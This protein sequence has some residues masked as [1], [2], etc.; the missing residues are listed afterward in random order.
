MN[1]LNKL[2][3]ELNL[4]K[5]NDPQELRKTIRDKRASLSS[6]QIQQVSIKITNTVCNLEIFKTS[7]IIASY[8]AFNSEVDPEQITNCIWQANKSCYL[9]FVK[10]DKMLFLKYEREDR[11]IKNR[12]GILEPIFNENKIISPEKIDLVI[13]PLVGFDIHC[14][15]LGT[16]KGYYDRTFAFLKKSSQH[17]PF[18]LGLAYEFQ[19]TSIITP[20]K[21][22]VPLDMIITEEKNYTTMP[23]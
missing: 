23:N 19:K 18:L 14:N 13:T 3:K 9:P 7:K 21:W 22:D 11:L 16:G 10:D 8:I 6:S 1:K 17:R 20:Q 15:R 4:N 2:W 5:N 12:V